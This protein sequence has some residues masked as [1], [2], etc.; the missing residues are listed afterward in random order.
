VGSRT[1]EA[2][3]RYLAERKDVLL[4]A[5]LFPSK[6]TGEMLHRN[7]I[8]QLLTRIGKRAGVAGVH[9]HRFRHTYAI[10]Y[11]RN[12]GNAVML[13]DLLGHTDMTMT[14][15]YVHLAE[16]DFDAAREQSP[17]DAWML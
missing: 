12:G 3:R 8:K 11:L 16:Q 17:V 9:A 13:Q 14:R 1:L 7:A 10:N 5:P 2:I 4:A 15:L 6:A